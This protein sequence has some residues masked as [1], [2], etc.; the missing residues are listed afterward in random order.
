M[1]NGSLE[2]WGGLECTV[3]RLGDRYR[4]QLVETGHRGRPGDLDRIA[5]LGIR[6]L[7]Y[8]VLW[9]SV[10]PDRP[11]ALNFRWHDRR[12]ARMA[13]LGIRPVVG[14]LHHGSGPRYTDLLDPA[15]PELFASYAG[16]VARRYPAIDL[17]TPVNEPLT[18]AR[19]SALYGHWYPHGR[20]L[21][22]CLRALVGQCL[23]TVLAMRAIRSV[24][25]AARLVQ[26]E[27]LG[28]VFARPALA[29]QAA[30]ENERRWLTF[31]LLFG[32]VDS[33]HPWW[34]AFREAGVPARDLDILRSE[35]VAP[36]IIGINH[37]LTSERYL[38]ER[39][40][41][42]PRHMAGGNGR[43]AYADVEA[44]RVPLP[45]GEVG[46]AARLRE[47][48]ERY[49]TPIAITEVHHGSTRDEQ[50]RWLAEIW[51]GAQELGREG[52]DIRAVTAWALVGTVD[53]NSLLTREDQIYEPGAFDTRPSSPRPTILARA[54]RDLATRGVTDHP[55][56][57]APGWW[58]RADRFYVR[59][60]GP[61]SPTVAGR[62]R[63]LVYGPDTP[64]RATLLR[65][66]SLRSLS[67]QV[68]DETSSGLDA[69][70]LSADSGGIW[71]VVDCQAG[72][73]PAGD[74]DRPD[75]IAAVC[76]QNGLPYVS[77]GES[78]EFLGARK[79]PAREGARLRT[80]R[81]A[82]RRE[83]WIRERHPDALV[84]RTGPLFGP[85]SD[86]D[87]IA[88]LLSDLAA[89]RP[90]AASDQL[91]SPTYLPD[92]A[93]VVLDLLVDGETGIWHLTSGSASWNDLVARLAGRTGLRA[94]QKAASPAAFL[95]AA[96]ETR[97][98]SIMP[99]LDGALD[100]WLAAS[101][102]SR[103]PPADPLEAAA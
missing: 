87:V 82:A 31:D 32:R 42:Y 75:R 7:R 63:I 66:A 8:P 86:E 97:R 26:T 1:G 101:E 20:S 70:Y 96:I 47:V 35:G 95:P 67:C 16:R 55:V 65:T 25:P 48:W 92:L 91:V 76:R 12:L 44:V 18:T 102:A 52:V 79:E 10:S 45:P 29:D 19:F 94:E 61:E 28:R 84:V 85:G 68:L 24:N 41:L 98:G 21:G 72:T 74:R 56:L 64:L 60:A 89:G 81:G 57:D 54:I 3:V 4:D 103:R 23:A 40:D 30:H 59:R 39:T 53:W 58:H 50:L 83:A 13:G 17:Y 99:P 49:R 78:P 9:E 38:D 51:G 27:D 36:D 11:D 2:L 88:R 34:R 37:Y 80:G 43:R 22:E 90:V 14:L 5:E 73:P 33:R 62:R 100:R 46:P 6:T 69:T 71:A 15:F 93:H 77:I